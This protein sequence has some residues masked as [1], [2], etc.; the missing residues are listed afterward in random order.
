MDGDKRHVHGNST[1][2]TGVVKKEEEELELS[3]R[4]KEMR[5]KR[6]TV[7]KT[8]KDTE[9]LLKKSKG[10]LENARRHG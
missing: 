4:R 9:K 5:K 1:A 7:T 2:D 10:K 8:Q 6:Q 3:D